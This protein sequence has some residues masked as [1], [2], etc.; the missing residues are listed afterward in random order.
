MPSLTL[1]S[2]AGTVVQKIY[3]TTQ[4]VNQSTSWNRAD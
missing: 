4:W 3:C 1:M 2:L